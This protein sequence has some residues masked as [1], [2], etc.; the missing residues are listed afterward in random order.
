M[1]ELLPAPTTLLFDRLLMSPSQ[2]QATALAALDG[3]FDAAEINLRAGEALLLLL[4]LL[5]A[6]L[7]TAALALHF[8]EHPEDL[9]ELAKTG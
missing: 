7:L 8:A 3:I 6:L 1:P 5:L 4:L 2:S 9:A